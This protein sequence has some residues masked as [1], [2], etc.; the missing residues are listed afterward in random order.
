MKEKLSDIVDYKKQDY[1]YVLVKPDINYKSD[2]IYNYLVSKGYKILEE[3]KIQKL[4]RTDVSFLYSKMINTDMFE[5]LVDYM[6]SGAITI[7]KVS[8]KNDNLLST[9]KILK[10]NMDPQKSGEDTLRYLF[11]NREKRNGIYLD[12]IHT[13]DSE[14]EISDLEKV[15]SRHNSSYKWKS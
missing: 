12:G 13:T 5:A 8:Y 4:D 1:G 2:L 6:T 7:Y 11:A 14:A 3:I 9:L 10:G 15:I